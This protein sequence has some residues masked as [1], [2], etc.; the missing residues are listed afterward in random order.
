MPTTKKSTTKR[1]RQ[2]DR[3]L[4]AGKQKH[5]V[6]AVS[7]KKRVSQKKVREAVKRVGHSRKAVLKELS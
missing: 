7:K 3:K 2:Q 1:G 6:K 4:V 5:E